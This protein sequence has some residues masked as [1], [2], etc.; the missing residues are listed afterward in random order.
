MKKL[1]IFAVSVL[2]A[3][4]SAFGENNNAK[5]INANMNP[6]IHSLVRYLDLSED[7][8]ESVKVAHDAFSSAVKHAELVCGEEKEA[9]LKNAMEFNAKNMREILTKE[10]YRKYM[11][12]FNVT[13]VNRGWKRNK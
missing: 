5:P 6:N 9:M 2:M 8:V 4:V 13:M 11:K 7:Q 12:A 10:Q 3:S 1:F